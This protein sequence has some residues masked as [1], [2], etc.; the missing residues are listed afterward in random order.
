M[1]LVSAKFIVT[2][3]FILMLKIL[4]NSTKMTNGTTL[5]TEIENQATEQIA[6]I[7]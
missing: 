1:A 5:V 7:N 2:I 3:F 6:R 4:I